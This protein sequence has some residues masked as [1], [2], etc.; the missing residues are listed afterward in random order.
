MTTEY[1]PIMYKC[2]RKGY[3]NLE[4]QS[5]F[6]NKLYN[7]LTNNYSNSKINIF[8]VPVSGTV[9]CTALMRKFTKSLGVEETYRRINIVHYPDNG[10]YQDI[11]NN[12]LN[13][14]IDDYICEGKALDKVIKRFS[15][16]EST[17]IDLIVTLKINTL[18]KY[19]LTG[20]SD[21]K[22]INNAEIYVIDEDYIGGWY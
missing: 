22:P 18:Y 15:R 7:Y 3:W 12:R 21:L 8:A 13:V 5:R 19:D 16:P 17:T 1:S 14:F 4:I 2:T 20:I 11:R 10:V 9:L 6:A